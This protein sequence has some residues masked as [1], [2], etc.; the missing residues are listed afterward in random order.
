MSSSLY[1]PS[2]PQ[3]IAEVLDSA[4]R[5]FRATLLRCLPY[6]A[7]AVV[8]GQL[9]NIYDI[10][11]GRPLRRFGAADPVWWALYLIG[12]LLALGLWNATALRQYGM[13]TGTG[14]AAAGA[15][16]SRGLRRAPVV[17]LLLTLSLAAMGVFLLPALL[18]PPGWRVGILLLLALPA[19]YVGVALSC[20]WTAL[21]LAGTGVLGSMSYSFRLVSGNWWRLSTIYT[22][23]IVML[24]VFY[25]LSG[26]LAMAVVVP[27]AGA[28]DLAVLTAVSAVVVVALGAVGTPFYSAL[29]LVV[30]GDLRARRE[31]LEV[32]RRMAAA[33]AE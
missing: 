3:S 8:A 15:D 17:A 16:L 11:A 6:G 7:L 29:A 4:F 22:V 14:T 19:S 26:V 24:L 25:V 5:V 2:R 12:A 10:A 31:A 20:S 23:G 27:F 9:P 1:P 21:L 32:E 33:A 13:L 28:A 30:F 18:V